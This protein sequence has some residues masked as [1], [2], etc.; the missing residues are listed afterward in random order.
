MK[1]M[2]IQVAYLGPEGTFTEAAFDQF[3]HQGAF[4]DPAQVQGVMVASPLEAIAAIHEAAADFACVAIEN[5]VDGSVTSTFDALA[6]QPGVQ[7]YHELDLPI[8][9]A[10]MVRP[11]TALEEV[12]SISAHPVA[13]QQVKKWATATLPGHE[14]LPASSNAAG[15]QAVAEGRADIAAAP[16]R[17]AQVYG[18]EIVAEDVADVAGARTRFVVVGR[19]GKPHP[20]AGADRTAVVFVLRNEPGSLVGALGEFSMR[21]VDLCRIESRPI[22]KGLGTYR[23]HVDINGHIEDE[24]VAEALSALYMRCESIHFL[25][26]WHAAGADAREKQL[27]EDIKRG[28]VARE[29]VAKAARG[30]L[31]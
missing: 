18:L 20:R 15:A 26:S 31:T 23:F 6:Y 11:G 14:F 29:W 2:S 12:R 9:F 5:S 24:P 21:G 4:G 8:T 13:Y 30:E 22:E 28:R 25:G 7:I 3:T 17:A 27:A 16:A 19:A 10:L 1:S